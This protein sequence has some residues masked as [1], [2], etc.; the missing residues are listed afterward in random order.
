MTDL[1]YAKSEL[2]NHTLVLCKER[3]LITSDKHGVAPM[4]D[5]LSDELDLSGYSAADIVVGKAVAMLFVL[6]KIKEVHAE[7]L[8]FEGKE[9]LEKNNIK[10]TYNKLIPHILNRTKDDLCPM[11]KVV[12]SL[13]NPS[14]AF[15][16][17][18]NKILELRALNN[19]NK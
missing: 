8:S 9:Y 16:A 1:E 15:V 3:S 14:E 10:V 7:V 4:L 11:E 18:K 2:A 13:D 12:H 19:V 5:F 17:L 6:A